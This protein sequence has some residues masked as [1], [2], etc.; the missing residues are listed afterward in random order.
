MSCTTAFECKWQHVPVVVSRSGWRQA[1]Y[2]D[3]SAAPQL[4]VH[5]TASRRASTRGSSGEHLHWTL[6][7]PRLRTCGSIHT[8]PHHMRPADRLITIIQWSH[9]GAI[10]G[11]DKFTFFWWARVVMERHHLLCLCYKPQLSLEYE[12]T[13]HEWRRLVPIFRHPLVC[14]LEALARDRGGLVCIS[15]SM[16]IFTQQT[17]GDGVPFWWRNGNV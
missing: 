7:F 11:R 10:K 9:N 3:K 4:L 1:C 16:W 15:Y 12:G 6:S 5:S 2:E 17:G 8:P 14:V 13:K